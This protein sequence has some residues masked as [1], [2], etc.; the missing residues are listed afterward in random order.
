LNLQAARRLVPA[1]PPS[2][3]EQQSGSAPRRGE[4][5]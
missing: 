3:D 4:L 1:E 5:G 2:G